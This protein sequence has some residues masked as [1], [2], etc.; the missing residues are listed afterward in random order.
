MEEAIPVWTAALESRFLSLSSLV[1]WADAEIMRR[2]E[3]PNWLMD[4]SLSRSPEDA[5]A[6]LSEGWIKYVESTGSDPYRSRERGQLHLG[7]LYLR[8]DRG[9]LSM[10]ELLRLAGE[11]AD[12]GDCG[13]DCEAFY[14]LL[15]EIDG[16]GPVIPSRRPLAERVTERFAPFAEMARR[17]INQL[18]SVPE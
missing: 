13:I 15:N 7:F 11:E 12:G 16:R 6:A 8:F 2:D 14:L 17:H 10:A 3:L 1:R 4:V 5:L 9:G 18:P